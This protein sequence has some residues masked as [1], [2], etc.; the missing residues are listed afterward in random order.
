MVEPDDTLDLRNNY[1]ITDKIGD[2][3]INFS[4]RVQKYSRGSIRIFGLN[5]DRINNDH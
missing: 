5:Q 2:E 1:S 4:Y 3:Q